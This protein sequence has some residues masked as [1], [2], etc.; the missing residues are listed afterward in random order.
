MTVA[1]RTPAPRDIATN[2]G[3]TQ[4]AANPY[5]SASLH[6]FSISICVAVGFNSV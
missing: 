1:V 4:T 6:I 3:G 5:S 2:G